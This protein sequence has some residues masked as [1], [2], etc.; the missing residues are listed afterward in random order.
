M[1]GGDANAADARTS[2]DI[3]GSRNSHQGWGR[4]VR[5]Q[6]Q[7][8]KEVEQMKVSRLI[9]TPAAARAPQCHVSTRGIQIVSPLIAGKISQNTLSDFAS[10]AVY[11]VD[12]ASAPQ[13]RPGERL[14][15][16]P[17]STRNGVSGGGRGH[18]CCASKPKGRIDEVFLE[19]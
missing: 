14:S 6:L 15:S 3:R 16:E 2:Q 10:A 9:F 4:R 18:L 8:L 1:E 19:P 12:A 13:N 7:L 11:R 17:D 5:F